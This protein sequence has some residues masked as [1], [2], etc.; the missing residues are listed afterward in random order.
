MVHPRPM[1]ELASVGPIDFGENDP[2]QHQV[3]VW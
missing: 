1:L 2:D 3:I